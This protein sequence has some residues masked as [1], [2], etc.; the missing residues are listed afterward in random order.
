MSQATWFQ[1]L[2]SRH[3]YCPLIVVFNRVCERSL[4]AGIRLRIQNRISEL[5]RKTSFLPC[6]TYTQMD[7]KPVISFHW[8]VYQLVPAIVLGPGHVWS[9]SILRTTHEKGSS[10]HPPFYKEETG[11]QRSW[12]IQGGPGRNEIQSQDL[13]RLG[14]SLH[15]RCDFFLSLDFTFCVGKLLS[16]SWLPRGVNL[17]AIWIDF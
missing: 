12:V 15:V 8:L 7:C 3:E 11:A 2:Q 16:A 6:A 5:N 9:L 17:L 10:S 14:S 4:Y 1:W 13:L